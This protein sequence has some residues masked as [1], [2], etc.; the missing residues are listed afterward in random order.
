MHL[1]QIIRTNRIDGSTAVESL[2]LATRSIA[3]KP[4]DSQ[5]TIPLDAGGKRL[6]VQPGSSAPGC[7]RVPV[8]ASI[9]CS[10]SDSGNG[11]YSTAT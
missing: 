2:N 1:L 7:G 6:C 3:Q 4:A 5:I 9:A 11:L 10:S 8:A